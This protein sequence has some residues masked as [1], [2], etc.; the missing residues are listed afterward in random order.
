MKISCNQQKDHYLNA[1]KSMKLQY[2]IFLTEQINFVSLV[3][4]AFVC[5]NDLCPIENVSILYIE[6]FCYIENLI[7]YFQCCRHKSNNYDI[8]F[9][10]NNKFKQ[11]YVIA[12][13][14]L[15]AWKQI[16]LTF[17]TLSLVCCEYWMKYINTSVVYNIW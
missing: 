14:C 2:M 5:R 16:I 6:T 8:Q 13:S 9:C 3:S 15:N 12:K 1:Q 4:I 7:L 17:E 11:W 10:T